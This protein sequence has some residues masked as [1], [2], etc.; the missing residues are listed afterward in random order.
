MCLK[1]AVQAHV[2]DRTHNYDDETL[3]AGA[4]EDTCVDDAILVRNIEENIDNAVGMRSLMRVLDIS[5]C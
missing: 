3:Y 2:D 1:I 4:L 5:E